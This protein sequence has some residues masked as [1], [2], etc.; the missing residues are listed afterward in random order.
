MSDTVKEHRKIVSLSFPP[1]VSGQPVVCNLSRLF[2]L[3]FNILRARIDPREEGHMT[4]EIIGPEEDCRRGEEYLRDHGVKIVPA[5]Q[6]VSREEDSCMHCGLC[7]AMCPSKALRVD[8]LSRLVLYDAERC[9]ACCVCAKVC[10]VKA[11]RVEV[12]ENGL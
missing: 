7:T 9:T 12:D 5:A 6:K 2:D 11:M 8:P 4:L 3:C 1:N 10:P